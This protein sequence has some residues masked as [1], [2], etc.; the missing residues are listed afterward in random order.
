MSQGNN[1]QHSK[2]TVSVMSLIFEATET[3]VSLG[4][5]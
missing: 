1:T 4:H 2:M 5:H 3:E